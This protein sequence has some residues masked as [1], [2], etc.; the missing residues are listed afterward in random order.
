[1]YKISVSGD[2]SRFEMVVLVADEFDAACKDVQH[3][4]FGAWRNRDRDIGQEHGQTVIIRE[5]RGSCMQVFSHIVMVEHVAVLICKWSITDSMN[6][7]RIAKMNGK[8][9]TRQ[10]L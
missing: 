2:S 6:T 5:E 7:M 3:H 10:T 1:M 8:A 4:C 9:C